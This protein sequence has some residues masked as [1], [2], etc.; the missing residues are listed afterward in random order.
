MFVIHVVVIAIH[1]D[2]TR[3]SD[4]DIL[5][6]QT[7]VVFFILLSRTGRDMAMLAIK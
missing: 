6:K 7:S 4:L 5:Y 2:S 1:L 3:E